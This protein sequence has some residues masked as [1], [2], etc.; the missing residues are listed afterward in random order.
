VLG[1]PKNSYTKKLNNFTPLKAVKS[2]PIFILV[3]FIIDLLL[4][5]TA[6]FFSKRR[7]TN[8]VSN[9]ISGISHDI[10][11]PLSMIMGYSGRIA[12]NDE[13]DTKTREEAAIIRNQ[14]IKIKDLILDL[15]LVTKL[16]YQI[17]PINIEN[18]RL[19]KILQTYVA[20]LENDGLE[21]KY[22]VEHDIPEKAENCVIA[23]DER[24]DLHHGLGLLLVR[25]IV[26]NHGGTIA[27]ESNPEQGVVITI[28]F[29][30]IHC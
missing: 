29:K 2:L 30:K 1:Y 23:C 21:D 27:I 6:Y 25:Q 12:S 3:V 4:L 26:K 20:E 9:W 10:R 14:I 22:S 7:I 16:E 28:T 5:F 18:V 17:Q 11:T 13:I 24:F 15:N 8:G 19:S